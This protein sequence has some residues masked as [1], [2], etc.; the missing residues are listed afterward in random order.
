MLC[1]HRRRHRFWMSRRTVL[2]GF[3]GLVGTPAVTADGEAEF[4]LGLTPVL[5]DNDMEF[6]SLL[7]RYLAQQ[8]DRPVKL[9]R[10]R[11]HREISV[12]LSAGQLDAAWISDFLYVQ[13]QDRLALLA[14]PLYRH[15]PFHQSYVIVN[16]ASKAGT[17]DDIRDTVHAFSDP[18]C[19]P[20]YLITRWL[21]ALRR[22]TPAEFFRNFFFTYG[23]R[24]VIR[25]VSNGLA[26]SG[27]TE[28]YVWDA[29]KER[30]P[31]FVAKTRIVF[32]SE[33]LG[34][35]PI[36]AL[37]TSRELPAI[38]RFAEALVGMA[39]DRLGSGILS[40]LRFDGFTRAR[41]GLYESTAE[42]WRVVGAGNVR[43]QR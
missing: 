18:D 15:Q 22:E 1:G 26:E 2:C 33:P 24:N 7:Q 31:D 10:R 30:E 17:F 12:M 11:T 28:G 39:S 21:L 29:M 43:A 36:V 23:H 4:S 38:Q 27:S 37:E 6:L 3:A 35:P 5:L 8:L 13:Y 42:K 20:G 41:P 19:T 9:V 16:E 14:V 25:A 34:S 32:R 40:I